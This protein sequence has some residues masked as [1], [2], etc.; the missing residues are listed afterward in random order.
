MDFFQ[1]GNTEDVKDY[2]SD[3]EIKKVLVDLKNKIESL[4]E[5]GGEWKNQ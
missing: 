3:E 2:L 5:Q 1:K 4:R